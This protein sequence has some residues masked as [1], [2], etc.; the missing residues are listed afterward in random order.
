MRHSLRNVFF[1]PFECMGAAFK[2]VK[3]GKEKGEKGTSNSSKIIISLLISIPAVLFLI[4][5]FS[6]ADEVFAYYVDA[7]VDWLRIDVSAILFDIIFGGLI[8]IYLFPYMF[9]LQSGTPLPV[10]EKKKRKGIDS[11]YVATFLGVCTLVYM[12]FTAV[13]IGYLFNRDLPSIVGSGINYAEYARKGFGELC[14][15]VALTFTVVLLAA[16][17][18]EKKENGKMSVAVQTVLTI[19]SASALV[20]VTSAICRLYWYAEAYGLT[21]NRV[22]SIWFVVVLALCTL[23]IIFK[24]W[25][26][27]I[28][29]TMICGCIVVA[30]TIVLNFA[31]LD[32]AVAN[33][34]VERY[35][36]G[37]ADEVDMYYLSE[38]S[39]AAT[40]AVEKLLNEDGYEEV[41]KSVLRYYY[42]NDLED[43]DSGSWT[44]QEM[45][46]KKII[47]GYGLNTYKYSSLN[48]WDIYN[49]N[50]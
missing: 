41:S 29:L 34:N 4:S 31:N 21:K 15:I 33:Y 32:Y 30:M 1:L 38:L 16:R 40:P 50:K 9:G 3:R 5:I 24:I 37:G 46:A 43:K 44:V 22:I 20:F 14:F 17:F 6:A 49:F 8:T 39:P 7:F 47:E 10:K 35:I 27:K 42:Y 11:V 19:L 45:K 2:S 36:N 13:Q 12:T 48:R 26:E 25:V 23:G 28:N 18:T